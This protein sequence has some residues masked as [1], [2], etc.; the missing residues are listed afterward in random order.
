[1][2]IFNLRQGDLFI[3]YL[4]LICAEGFSALLNDARRSEIVSGASIA[5]CRLIMFAILSKNMRLCLG[6]R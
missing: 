6:S 1:M 5:R 2:I 3:P 4:F